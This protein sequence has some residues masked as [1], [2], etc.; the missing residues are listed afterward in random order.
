MSRQNTLV[1]WLLK[2]SVFVI[3][4]LPVAAAMLAVAQNQYANPV[5]AILQSSGEWALRMLMFTLFVTPLQFWFKWGW[6][7]RLRRM[8][9]LYA[10]FY[11]SLHLAIWLALDQELD[12]GAAIAAVIEKPFITVGM[13]TFAGLLPLALT[14]NRFSVR[15]LGRRWKALHLWVYPLTVLAIVHLVWQVKG[16]ELLEPAIYLVVLIALYS[17]R[18]GRLLK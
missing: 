11:A 14:S 15:K 12:V 3:C 5:E 16:N 2:P 10:F 6:V 8:L 1:T 9:G 7:A 4:L 13:L 17:W 18:F